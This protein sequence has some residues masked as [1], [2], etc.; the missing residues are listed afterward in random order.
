MDPPRPLKTAV[1]L[2]NLR[3]TLKKTVLFWQRSMAREQ[4]KFFAGELSY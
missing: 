1:W 3:E 2:C 4:A